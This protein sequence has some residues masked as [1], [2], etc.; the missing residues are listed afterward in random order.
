M[1]TWILPRRIPQLIDVVSSSSL[2]TDVRHWVAA[3]CPVDRMTLVLRRRPSRITD[4]AIQRR[5]AD[6]GWSVASERG[7]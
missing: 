3:T 5:L 1:H 6:A 4:L 7:Q 2:F